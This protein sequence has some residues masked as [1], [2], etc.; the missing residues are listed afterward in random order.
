MVVC[1]LYLWIC[2]WTGNLWDFYKYPKILIQF[3]YLFDV[4][5]GFILVVAF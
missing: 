5:D 2:G 1:P 4:S 3:I